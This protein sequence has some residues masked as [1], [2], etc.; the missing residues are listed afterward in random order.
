MGNRRVVTTAAALMALAICA[1]A[2]TARANSQINKVLKL[3]PGGR[4]VLET[5]AGTVSVMGS[6]ESGA[7]VVVTSNRDDLDR[8][9]DFSFQQ[10]PGDVEVRAQRRDPWDFFSAIFGGFWLHYDVRVPKNTRVEIRTS[11][12]EIKV[13]ALAGDADLRTSGGLI[14]A[15]Q[16]TGSLRASTSGG[17]VRV[18]MIHGDTDLA[19]SGGSIDADAVDGALTARTS[20]GWIRMSGVAGRVDARTSGGWI[21]A[22]LAKGNSQGGLLA[23]SGGWIQAKI[24][25][26]ANLEI[27]A[28]TSGGGVRSDLP[29]H[30]ADTFSRGHL[31]GTLGSGGAMLRMRTSGGWIRISGL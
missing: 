16:V 1:A 11:G 24:D 12:G 15:S 26:A 21:V 27:D 30:V 7:D 5:F 6:N 31:H 17:S 23:T 29:L 18:T 2:G 28:S 4:F 25:P 10:N 8:R 3:D 19:T 20:G 13:F 14:E 9:V 22:A